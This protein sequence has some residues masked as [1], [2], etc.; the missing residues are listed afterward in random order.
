MGKKIQDDGDETQ[1]KVKAGDK[2]RDAQT[3]I[4]MKTG[5]RSIDPQTEL[6]R[7]R[8]IRDEGE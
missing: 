1:A 4:R 8:R 6:N 5:D 3:V 7:M 2:V